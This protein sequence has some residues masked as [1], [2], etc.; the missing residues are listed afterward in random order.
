MLLKPMVGHAEVEPAVHEATGHVPVA[1]FVDPT[2][3]TQPVLRNGRVFSEE[4]ERQI[5]GRWR[6]CRPKQ[7]GHLAWEQRGFAYVRQEDGFVVHHHGGL[8]RAF[9]LV[10]FRRLKVFDPAEV[11][12]GNQWASGL[13]IVTTLLFTPQTQFSC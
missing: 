10:G 2:N 8:F 13:T 1:D 4:T 3:K 5:F 9:G 6:R 11:S 7:R 12:Q